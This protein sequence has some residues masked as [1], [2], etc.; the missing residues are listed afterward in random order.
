MDGT[1]ASCSVFSEAFFVGGEG[2]LREAELRIEC[3]ILLSLVEVSSAKRLDLTALK[4]K[5][6]LRARAAARAK[7]RILSSIL[8]VV[9]AII[10]L[11]DAASNDDSNG[12][13]FIISSNFDLCC[14]NSA[15][16]LNLAELGG[17]YDRF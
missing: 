2:E 1:V 9:V 3:W 13:Q 7:L 4:W 14:E 5:C 10:P 16:E 15:V 6:L 8:M 12:G 17:K 11:I